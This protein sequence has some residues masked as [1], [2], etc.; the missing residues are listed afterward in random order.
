MLETKD[1]FAQ[2]SDMQLVSVG[3][4]HRLGVIGVGS[5]RIRPSTKSCYTPQSTVTAICSMS[6]AKMGGPPAFP[7][8]C[9]ILTLGC[10][11]EAIHITVGKADSV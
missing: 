8:D 7:K 5:C 1:C 11:N 4:C 3:H 10:L 9:R 2:K 6:N